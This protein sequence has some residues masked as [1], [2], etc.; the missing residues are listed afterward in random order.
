MTNREI[1]EFAHAAIFILIKDILEIE[2]VV[3][4]LIFDYSVQPYIGT[5]YYMYQN[6]AGT[7]ITLNMNSIATLKVANDI[8]T[9][10]VYSFIHEIIHMHQSIYS[11]YKTDKFYYSYIEDSADAITIKYIKENE[12]LINSRLNFIFNDV[13]LNGI[14]RQLKHKPK[15]KFN[16]NIHYYIAKT[17]AGT[18]ST[19]LNYNF[20]YLYNLIMDANTMI[21]IFPD[22]RKYYIDLD[23]EQE[24]SI[25]TLVNLLNLTE[26]RILHIDFINQVEQ[27]KVKE[28][29]IILY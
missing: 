26:Y 25:S 20:D 11:Y 23:Y 18:L 29:S 2:A 8:K 7:T 1:E 21:I 12:K 28:L 4:R 15:E 19:K 10:I 13:F 24:N 17:I 27:Y 16:F 14:E 22:K 9:V 5:G 6:A 3:P